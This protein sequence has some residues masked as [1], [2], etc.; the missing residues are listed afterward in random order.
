[1]QGQILGEDGAVSLGRSQEAA[2]YF[3][4]AFKLSH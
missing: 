3:D 1:M 2:E 4:R